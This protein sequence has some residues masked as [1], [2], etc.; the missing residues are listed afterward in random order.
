M[1]HFYS[2]SFQAMLLRSLFHFP[3]II[4]FFYLLTGKVW[5]TAGQERFRSITQ[6]YYRGAGGMFCSQIVTLGSY[7]EICTLWDVPNLLVASVSL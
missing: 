5:D 7:D 2:I 6:T 1:P 3:I 4:I